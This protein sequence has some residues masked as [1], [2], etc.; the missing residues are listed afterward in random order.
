MGIYGQDWASY[1]GKSPDA[2]G[3]SFVFIKVTE[4][5]SYVN[6]YWQTQ[7]A[8]AQDAGAV[9]GLYHYPYMHN[10][11][12][13][14]VDAFL[15]A[16][17]VSTGEMVVLDWEGYDAN[18]A[19]V[20]TDE[21]RAYKEQFLTT[22]K[23]KLPNNPVGL[24]CSVDYWLNVDT[25]SHSG[26]F[27]WIADPGKNAGS[28]GIRDPWKFHQ[29][30]DNGVDK[31]Y[32][33]FASTQALKDWVKSFD[34]STPSAPKPPPTTGGGTKNTVPDWQRL[35]NHVNSIPEKIYETWTSSVGWDNMTPF[36]VEYGENGVAWCVIFNWDMYHD[37]G[38]D[39]IVPKTDNVTSFSDWAKAR[40]QWSEYPSVGAWV[41]FG[42][43]A[44]TE[45]V[46]GFDDTFVYTKGGN[47]IP[48]GAADQGQGDGVW[49]HSNHRTDPYVT[50]Y[51]APKFA[52]GVCP[53]TA[54]PNDYRK[55]GGSTPPPPKPPT[56]YVP[57]PFPSGIGPNKS[58]PSAKKLQQALKDTGWMDKSVTL[59]DNY[60]PLTQAGVAGFNKKHNLNDIG[61][62][63]DPAIG[64]RGWALLFTL[65]YG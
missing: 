47:S 25:T 59:A 40:G 4:G 48:T 54:D 1:Q 22:M 5:E 41:N 11:V 6:P 44:H 50:G 46:T 30:D 38:M 29:Y 14:E 8:S 58:N 65:A 62:N 27:L 2:S 19:S 35:V 28:P 17:K 34:K 13:D 37:M 55:K 43:G 10:A 32:G 57:P 53:P 49:P 56:K 61:V 12:T 9:I 39:S 24:Y 23:Q 31:D 7:K 51:F 63:Y 16:A 45:I 20:S 26:D 33:D 15:N 18:N 64:P 3:L 42:N 36:G 52:D 21:K 60:G